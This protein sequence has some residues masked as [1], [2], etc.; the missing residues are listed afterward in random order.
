MREIVTVRQGFFLRAIAL[1][2][3]AFLASSGAALAQAVVFDHGPTTGVRTGPWSN[4]TAAQ[5]FADRAMLTSPTLITGI[6]IYT[7]VAPIAGT[8][9]VKILSDNTGVPGSVLYSLD[10]TPDAWVVD[11]PSGGYKVTVQLT[12]TFVAAAGTTY[13]YGM[14]GN[15]FDLGQFGVQA[16][17][18]SRM[19]QFNAAAPVGL[20]APAVGDQMF[21]LLGAPATLVP[22]AGTIGLIALGLLLAVA[23]AFVIRRAF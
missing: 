11:A 3:I 7:A 21:Q 5:N 17:E 19:Y 20:T 13:W 6:S 8:V 15:I 9:H 4:G 23:G 2:A 18:D 14:S 12:S 16:P 22:A 10:K 1:M